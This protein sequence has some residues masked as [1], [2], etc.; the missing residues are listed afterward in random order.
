MAL[1]ADQFDK[2]NGPGAADRLEA[3]RA[4]RREQQAQVQYGE[5]NPR[6]ESVAV[7]HSGMV[8]P[9]AS[10]TIHQTD[11]HEVVTLPGQDTLQA[12][13]DQDPILH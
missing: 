3:F 1:S 10:R 4:A 11:E 13:D 9:E 6:L 12:S 2:I 5:I 8:P 7:R